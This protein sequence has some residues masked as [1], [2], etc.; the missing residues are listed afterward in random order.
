MHNYA[1]LMELIEDV[2]IMNSIKKP[3]QE[4]YTV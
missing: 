4:L 3:L 2:L 1:Q